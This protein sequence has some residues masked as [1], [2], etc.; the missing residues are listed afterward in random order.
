MKFFNIEV[1]KSLMTG[2]IWHVTVLPIL[3][4]KKKAE[5]VKTN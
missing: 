4:K 3:K 2:N 5:V 1:V